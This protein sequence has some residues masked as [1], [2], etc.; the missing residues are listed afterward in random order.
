M[1]DLT[2]IPKGMSLSRF[3]ACDLGTERMAMDQGESFSFH[4]MPRCHEDPFLGHVSCTRSLPG[5]P[6]D[7]HLMCWHIWH[8][9]SWLLGHECP[10]V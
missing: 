3:P 8:M 7:C 6:W 4:V 1:G 5:T 2:D 9:N 10:D